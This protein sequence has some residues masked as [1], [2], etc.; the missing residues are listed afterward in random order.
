MPHLRTELVPGEEVQVGIRPEHLRPAGAVPVRLR[1][2]VIELLGATAFIHGELP[3][4]KPVVAEWRGVPPDSGETIT[5]FADPV[6][7]RL[8]DRGGLRIR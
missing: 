3:S 2:E 8:F 7:V 1:V 6:E 4:G 5:V